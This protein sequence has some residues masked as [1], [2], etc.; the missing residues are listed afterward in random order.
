MLSFPTPGWTLTMDLPAGVSG[1]A[2]LLDRL[3]RLVLDVGGRHYLAKDATATPA[4]IRAGYPRLD[5]WRAVRRRVDPTGVWIS[6]QA[7]RL[8]LV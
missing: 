7:R 2:T 1:L 6:D 5:E 4:M 8:D 3:D